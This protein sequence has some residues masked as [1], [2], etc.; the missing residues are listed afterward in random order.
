MPAYYLR[1][2]GCQMNE[3]DA[4]RIRAVLEDLGYESVG[5]PRAADVLIYNTCTVR[6]S[7]DDRLAGHLGTA[8]RAKREDPRRVIA[9]TGCLPQA[10][11]AAFFARF[12]FVDV[13]LGPQNLHRLREAILGALARRSGA[14][15]APQGYFDDGPSLSSELPSRRGR[16][17]QAW[18][19]VMSGCTNFCSYCIV[20]YVRGSERS[21]L[22]HDIE[23]EVQ[24]LVQDGVK[25]ITLLGQNVN[26]YGRDL[27]SSGSAPTFAQLLRRLDR[28]PG[29]QRTRFMTSHPKDLSDELVD[30]IAYLP[31]VCE[32][33]HLPAQSGSDRI[34]AAMRRGYTVQRYLERVAALRAATPDVAITTDLI[35]GFPGET[36]E[37]FAGTLALVEAARFDAAFTFVYSPRPGTA[38]ASFPRQVDGD[39]KRDR[40]RRLIALTQQVSAERRARFVN[41]RLDVLVEG[42]S[43]DGHL[44][45][46]RTRH[47]VTVNFTGQARPGEVAWVLI[48]G[49]TSTSLRGKL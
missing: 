48:T 47:N 21:R 6:H 35:V 46:G 20:P 45:R 38:A 29:L 8:A 1:S 14:A 33:V 42:P 11:R 37:D 34:L 9:V 36:E 27:D 43:R 15:S 12:P 2:F 25:E 39:I 3:H 16:P 18:V 19:Q 7:A 17:Y 49:A 30:A 28:L 5:E 31:T 23:A 44:L 41:R 13:A 40:V 26:A 4:E 22:P 10:E 24:A 32:H